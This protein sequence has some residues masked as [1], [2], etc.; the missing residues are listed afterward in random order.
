P[1][2]SVLI[3]LKPPEAWLRAH[4]VPLLGMDRAAALFAARVLEW[5]RNLWAAGLFLPRLLDPD[6]EIARDAA[7]TLGNIGDPRAVGP[8]VEALRT[9]REGRTY[10]AI[11]GALS[12]LSGVAWDRDR[13]ADWWEDWWA[14][15]RARF[16]KGQTPG[17]PR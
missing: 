13:T 16:E 5:N 6:P 9:H 3:E 2:L 4:V 10:D 7:S 15:N 17:A 1:L 11:S 12:N 8:L 14:R